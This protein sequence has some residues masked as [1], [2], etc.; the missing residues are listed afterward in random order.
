MPVVMQIHSD[1]DFSVFATNSDKLYNAV[2]YVRETDGQVEVFNVTSDNPKYSKLE[3][4]QMHEILD[5]FKRFIGAAIIQN[6]NITTG[7]LYK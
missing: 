2:V 3:P 5:A 1:T 6:M 7:V 4:K